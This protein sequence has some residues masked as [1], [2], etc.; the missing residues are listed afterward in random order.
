MDV[1]FTR[2]TTRMQ[3][4]PAGTQDERI[5]PTAYR[6]MQHLYG[7]ALEEMNMRVSVLQR[8]MALMSRRNPI[9]HVQTRIKA[10]SSICEKLAR[11]GY[12]ISC[13]SA[14]AHLY[15]IAGMRIVCPT[16]QDVYAVARMVREIQGV[17]VVRERDYIRMPKDNG[18]RSLHIVLNV[19]VCLIEGTRYVPVEVQV[20]TLAM[21]VWASM[22]HDLC[23]KRESDCAPKAMKEMQR[24]SRRMA[25]VDARLSA[26]QKEADLS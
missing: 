3:L 20:R 10:F 17:Y 11:K 8:E 22:E 4:V 6:R 1:H 26:L 24:L 21:D 2:A 25:E 5:S 14:Q 18:Y 15:D 9:H 7:A 16:V 23:Y 13:E 19:P 12:D